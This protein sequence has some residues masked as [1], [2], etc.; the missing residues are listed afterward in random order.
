MDV[1]RRIERV[2]ERCLAVKV[3]EV[4]WHL[5]LEDVTDSLDRADLSFKVEEEMGVKGCGDAF[6]FGGL[7]IAEA[8]E[9]AEVAVLNQMA[10]GLRW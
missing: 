1:K 5:P 8:C 9:R 6:L 3:D 10:A 7:T 2:V 4:C